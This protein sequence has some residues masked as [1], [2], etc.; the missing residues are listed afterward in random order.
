M[1]RVRGWAGHG[2]N[3]YPL[4]KRG[5]VSKRNWTAKTHHANTFEH[6]KSV[7]GNPE[8]EMAVP[9]LFLRSL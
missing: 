9:I 5:M 7:A 3:T 6:Y 4:D 1:L 8:W 2:R